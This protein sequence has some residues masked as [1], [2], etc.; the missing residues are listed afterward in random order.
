MIGLGSCGSSVGLAADDGLLIAS[1]R[2]VATDAGTL[3][4]PRDV[5]IRN[6]RIER[7]PETG[8]G[9]GNARCERFNAAGEYLMP[10]LLDLHI[11]LEADRAPEDPHL[12][13]SAWYALLAMS[14][15]VPGLRGLGSCAEDIPALRSR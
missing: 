13:L 12:D 2:I 4:E 1:V 7:I 8:A 10:G 3:S 6:G 5:L 14:C 11:H 15:S 9:C